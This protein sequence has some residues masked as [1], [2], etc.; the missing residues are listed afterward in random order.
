MSQADVQTARKD[1]TDKGLE[2]LTLRLA[3]D[4]DQKMHNDYAVRVEG[5]VPRFFKRALDGCA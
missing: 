1:T 2:K 3:P 4:F 5:D